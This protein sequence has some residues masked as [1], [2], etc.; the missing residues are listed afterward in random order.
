MTAEILE[1]ALEGERITE[2]DAVALLRS[3]D[4]V[5]IGRAALA[6]L[7]RGA[8]DGDQV[9]RAKER[10]GV[11]LGD[12]LALERPV[13]DLGDH[14]GTGSS[15]TKRSS[16]TWSSSPAS[17]ASSRNVRKPARSRGPKR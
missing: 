4:L 16:G 8:A 2:D 9:A 1:R 13:E 3:R 10:D 14:A 11:V 12:P 6:D 5:A 7:L 17:R 15:W